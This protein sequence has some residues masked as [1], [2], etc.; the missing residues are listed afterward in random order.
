MS[1]VNN[2]KLDFLSVFRLARLLL[3]KK[4]NFRIFIVFLF[5]DDSLIGKINGNFFVNVVGQNDFVPGF[6]RRGNLAAIC[7]IFKLPETN[8]SRLKKKENKKN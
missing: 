2:L 7:V 3:Y 5:A 6:G 4:G 8:L 1:S